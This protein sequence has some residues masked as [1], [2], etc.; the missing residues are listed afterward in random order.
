MTIAYVAQTRD[1]LLMLDEEGVCLHVHRRHV[2]RGGDSSEGAVRCVGAQ[3]VAALDPK[4]PGFLTQSPTL[5][6]P[7]L[8][9]KMSANGKISLVRTG[10]LERF[11]VRGSGE[12]QRPDITRDLLA[13]THR[14]LAAAPSIQYLP[15]DLT[16]DDEL[17]EDEEPT[18]RIRKPIPFPPPPAVPFAGPRRPRNAGAA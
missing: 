4:E 16:E 10:A 3:Y 14:T 13:D 15:D 9:A 17:E 1:H 18:L 11:E 2:D 7:M 6:A 5:G 12:H 8:F